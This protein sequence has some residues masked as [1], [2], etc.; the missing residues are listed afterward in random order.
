MTIYEDT[1]S[2]AEFDHFKILKIPTNFQFG[3]IDPE[4]GPSL[5][6]GTFQ[7]DNTTLRGL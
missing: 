2:N 5:Q 1:N 3:S 7:R 4:S 6:C